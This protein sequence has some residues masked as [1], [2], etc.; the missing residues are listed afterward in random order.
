MPE[1][2]R[3]RRPAVALAL[4]AI[5]WAGL[6]LHWAPAP[7]ALAFDDAWYYQTIARHL[8]AGDGFTHDGLQ[9]TNGFHPLW[10]LAL[11]GL[12]ALPLGPDGLMR[13]TLLL[14][15]ALVVGLLF[16]LGRR[17]PRAL[18]VAALLLVSPYATKTLVNGMESAFVAAL[19]LLLVARAAAWLRAGAWIRLG[20][21][22][23]ALAL[24]RVEAL[25]FVLAY[26]AL[27][28]REHPRAAVKSGALAAAIVASWAL[29]A[30]IAFGTPIPVSGLHLSSAPSL[31]LP[32]AAGVVVAA[33]AGALAWRFRARPEHAALI[34]FAGAQLAY[35]L[36]FQHLLPPRLWYL[37][38][39]T[40]AALVLVARWRPTRGVAIGA[41][42][43][44]LVF[45][46]ATWVHRLDPSSYQSYEAA[47]DDGRWLAD[48]LAADELAAGWDVGIVGAFSGGRAVNLEGLVAAP[49]YDPRQAAAFLRDH[50]RIRYVAQYVS[51]AHLC[52]PP[53]LRIEGVELED[54]TVLRH[55]EVAHRSL[56][57]RRTAVLHRLVLATGERDGTPLAELRARVCA[58]EAR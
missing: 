52:A 14:Q 40:A 16:A 1:P 12:G 42:A 30:T 17:E 29:Y 7:F 43:L 20:A 41:A 28:A 36:A 38:P 23:G 9:P 22:L 54:R 4:V 24:S 25:A 6:I 31:D 56:D 35:A 45:S 26:L 21:A 18:W 53:P 37:A 3:D 33:G 55:T 34:A 44:W 27:A 46:A 51:E 15:L 10:Q 48:H 49:S 50:P 11:A 39:A 2:T 47:R 5:G 58:R 13:L 19:L 32:L 57:P 8:A